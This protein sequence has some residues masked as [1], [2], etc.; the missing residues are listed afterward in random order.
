VLSNESS[1]SNLESGSPTWQQD[2]VTDAAHRLADFFA[3]KVV[4]DSAGSDLPAELAPTSPEPDSALL[5]FESSDSD[6]SDPDFSDS[7]SPDSPLS[8]SEP[9]TSKLLNSELLNSEPPNLLPTSNPWTD[10][11]PDDLD[12]DDDIP[13]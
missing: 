2:E 8:P 13:F 4:D 5:D 1:P 6:L 11:S 9:L 12:E 10:S 7:D 3:G